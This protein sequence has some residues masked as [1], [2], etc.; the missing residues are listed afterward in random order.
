MKQAARDEQFEEAGTLRRQLFAL[1]HIQDISLIKEEYRSV[2]PTASRIEAYDIAH[3]AGSAAVGVMTVVEDG[4]AERNEYRKFR[5]RSAKGG[6][7]AGALR[8]VLSR[9][10]G[11]D[12]WPMPKLI[13]VDGSMVQINAAKKVLEQYGFGIPVVG[14][15]KDEKHRPREIK[16][17]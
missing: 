2:S 7:D 12:E 17:Q 10:L 3:L 1:Q 15:V 6:D 13:V 8:E 11:H 4:A 16:G 9:R 5:I 14:V